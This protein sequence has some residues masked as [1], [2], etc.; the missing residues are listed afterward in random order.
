M[1]SQRVKSLTMLRRNKRLKRI[2]MVLVLV[3]VA[4]S[5]GAIAQQSRVYQNFQNMLVAWDR[6][7][8]IKEGMSLKDAFPEM[9]DLGGRRL[10]VTVT[11][12]YQQEIPSEYKA[13]FNGVVDLWQ[14]SNGRWSVEV[15][16]VDDRGR[17]LCDYNTRANRVR[18]LR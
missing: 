3:L 7:L 15:I 11:T 18:C 17:R 2:V 14:R 16:F 9:K 5:E 12:L 4:F 13:L 8:F 10:S 1:P 6:R